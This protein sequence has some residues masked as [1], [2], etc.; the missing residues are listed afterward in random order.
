MRVSC[1]KFTAAIADAYPNKQWAIEAVEPDTEVLRLGPQ[2]RQNVVVEL[3]LVLEDVAESAIIKQL[4]FVQ[5][6]QFF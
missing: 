3:C 2:L 5:I 1:Q 6:C 4:V